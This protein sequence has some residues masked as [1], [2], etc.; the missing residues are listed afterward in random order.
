MNHSSEMSKRTIVRKWKRDYQF[1]K[2]GNDFRKGSHG[3]KAKRPQSKGVKGNFG[4]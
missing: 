4:K 1:G 2:G 3:A